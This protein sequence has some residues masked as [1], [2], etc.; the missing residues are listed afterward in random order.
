MIGKTM[1]CR[2][3]FEFNSQHQLDV[4]ENDGE[5]IMVVKIVC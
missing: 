3:W 4:V 1:S 2:C 5:E